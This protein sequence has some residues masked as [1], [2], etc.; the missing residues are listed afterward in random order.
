MKRSRVSVS[1]ECRRA[2]P[3][4]RP[5][6]RGARARRS[7][8][9]RDARARRSDATAASPALVAEVGDSGMA[10][11]RRHGAARLASEARAVLLDAMGTL[12]TSSDPAPQ[13][14]AALLERL[15][16]DVG[17]AAARRRDP[18]RDRVLPRAPPRGAR[19]GGAGRAAPRVGG[20][21]APGARPALAARRRRRSPPRCS[22]RSRFTAYPD[23]APALR[24]LRAGGCAL[25]VVSNWDASLHERLAEAGLA[26]CVDGAVASAEL[27]AAKPDGAIFARGLAL[28]GRGARRTRGTSAT[29]SPRTSRARWRRGSAPVLV[30]RDG[31]PPTL[32]GV[33][34]LA[35]WTN[36]RARVEPRR[37]SAS[38]PASSIPPPSAGPPGSLPS[39]PE[40]P[41]GVWRPEPPPPPSRRSDG[42][43]ALAALGA[44]R[45][46]A[47]H[48]GRR[49]RRRRRDRPRR[50]AGRASTRRG[51]DPPPGV[52]IGGTYVQDL[53]LIGAR[54]CSRACS[55]RRRRR[56]EFGLRP[57]RLARGRL[58]AARLGR[59]LRVLGVWASRL[60]INENDD[61]P[62]ELGRRRLD[63]RAGRGRGPR[64][65]CS[66]R[67]PRS[68]SSAA[69]ASPRC[70]GASACCRPPCSP[71][72]S[73]APSTW[74]GT[75]IEFIV[76]LMVSA[77]SSA[78]STSGPDSLLPCIGPARAQQR[79][80]ARASRRSWGAATVAAMVAAAWPS[81]CDRAPRSARVARVGP[82]MTRATAL[83][84][85][86]AAGV[87]AA[88]VAQ[89]PVAPAAAA[90]GAAPPPRRRRR[91]RSRP[92][93]CTSAG[94]RGR[95]AQARATASRARS[96]PP[97]AGRE[98]ASCSVIRN[99]K[100]PDGAPGR[101]GGRHASRAASS[102]AAGRY[103]VRACH[104]ATPEL[105]ASRGPEG[106]RRASSSRAPRRRARA[107]VRLLQR[108]LD[109]AA[110]RRARAT[111]PTTP[112]P[113][114]P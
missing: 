35:A 105:A 5:A 93:R 24:A 58:D 67:S 98:G 49:A 29:T 101:A 28:A 48:A 108:G 95:A 79:A 62:Q 53:A 71:A 60:D 85:R 104:D 26:G 31:P 82:R 42:L 46:H 40:L 25:V 6:C 68:C 44:V 1:G 12:L 19:R 94:K 43:P 22:T 75:D 100:K 77:S 113:A 16:V 18:R 109:E 66:R 37:P 76:P 63:A 10:R 15:G 50:R 89:D 59:V 2:S 103:S 51:D 30:H 65:A 11:S 90:S 21:D 107:V 55:T 45:R 41:D 56:R 32:P 74:V 88:A 114:A 106:E 73:S 38:G 13:L 7:S 34:V 72:S 36:C 3:P 39:R 61:L 20:G 96:R 97:C 102:A 80:R 47:R 92:P 99:G 27:G 14:R 83:A 70:G 87:P 78:S 84:C 64:R 112:R 111:T 91:S 17:E 23:V 8:S 33:P 54:C 81:S 57:A 4:R 9:E 86:R 110:L 69:S 52:T